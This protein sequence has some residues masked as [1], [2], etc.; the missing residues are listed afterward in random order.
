[1]KKLFQDVSNGNTIIE[2][3]PRPQCKQGHVLIRTSKSL[4]SA[5]TERM[6]VDFG[7]ANYIDKARQQ[8][9]KVK[10]VLDKVKTDGLLTTI[11][12]VKSKL[13]QPLPMGY[14]NVGIVE[15]VA[16]GIT[17][18]KIGDRVLSNGSHSEMVCV[19]KNLVAHIPDEVSDED[20]SFTVVSSI[21]LQGI[22]L[23]NPTIGEKIVVW[24]SD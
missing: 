12:A 20:A 11:D 19:P 24:A 15:E 22:R 13:D 9:E 5:G 17:E 16:D 2:E 14:S 8:P 7:K 4:I 23:L 6:L 10:M 1:M 3:L 21:A 18:F